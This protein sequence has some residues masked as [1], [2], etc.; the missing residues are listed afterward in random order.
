[1]GQSKVT[2]KGTGQLNGNVVINKTVEMDSAM[3]NKFMGSS[4]YEVIEAFLNTNYPGVKVNPKNFGVNVVPIKS[5]SEKSNTSKSSSSSKSS[6]NSNKS[7]LSK[8]GSAVVGTAS[9]IGAI[10]GFLL[11]SDDDEENEDAK[12]EAKKAEEFNLNKEKEKLDFE[13]YK[14]QKEVEFAN[15][16]VFLKKTLKKEKIDRI[17]AEMD[18]GGNKFIGYFSIFWTYLDKWW[19]K[20]IFIYI[21]LLIISQIAISLGYGK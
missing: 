20:A 7:L 12:K 16:Q 1:M 11:N 4:R 13:Y 17:K 9:V 19:K 5:S 14:K 21:I 15:Q 8:T 2:I 3:A 10:G 18:N 6:S